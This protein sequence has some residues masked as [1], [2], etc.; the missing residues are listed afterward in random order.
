MIFD[1]H[2]KKKSVAWLKHMED[3]AVKLQR[4]LKAATI[5][6][7]YGNATPPAVI[8]VNTITKFITVIVSEPLGI[9]GWAKREELVHLIAVLNNGVETQNDY[10]Y[11]ALN[12][13]KRPAGK[14]G[15]LTCAAHLYL[16][17]YHQGVPP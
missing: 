3:T 7:V 11:N 13:W 15:F 10:T 5:V 4:R 17:C 8:V 16:A 12:L 6:M 14:H 1:H 9:E 2:L